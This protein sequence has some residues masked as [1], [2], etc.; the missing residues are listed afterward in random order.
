MNPRNLISSEH[1]TRYSF[2]LWRITKPLIYT[3]ALNFHLSKRVHYVIGKNQLLIPLSQSRPWPID[4]PNP[5]TSPSSCDPT[6][7]DNHHHPMM[8]GPSANTRP[9]GRY[10]RGWGVGHL[11]GYR[12]GRWFR[13]DFA[14]GNDL[15]GG[16]FITVARQSLTRIPTAELFSEH[17]QKLDPFWLLNPSRAGRFLVGVLGFGR[18]DGGCEC[19]A[20]FSRIDGSIPLN[21][22]VF[23]EGNK[24]EFCKFV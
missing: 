23:K 1:S 4:F 6:T 20:C 10:P 19:G 21:V 12:T 5:P 3:N 16:H 8:G 13:D 11:A 7:T 18:D 24:K 2:N 17:T 22:S 15:S 9:E 14:V